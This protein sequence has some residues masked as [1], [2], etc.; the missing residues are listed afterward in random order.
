[1]FNRECEIS[2]YKDSYPT[3]DP[4]L[5]KVD[6]SPVISYVERVE[7]PNKGLSY[8]DFSLQSLIDADAIDLLNPVSPISRDSL[9]AADLANSALGNIGVVADSVTDVDSKNNN[10]EK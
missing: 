6:R 1:M 5:T 4:V 10:D 8:S 9:F 7:D 3:F 2:F